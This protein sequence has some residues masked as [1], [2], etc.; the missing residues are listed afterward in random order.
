MKKL[1]TPFLLSLILLFASQGI[2]AQS[3]PTVTWDGFFPGGGITGN[4][5]AN[6]VKQTPDGGFVLVGT[7]SMTYQGN[8]YNEA[9]IMRIDQDG[10]EIAMQQTSSGA[11]QGIPWDQELNDLLITPGQKTT[12]LVTGFR[13]TTLLSGDTPPGL[14]LME[15]GNDGSVIF[16]SLYYNDNLHNIQGY[17]I[18]PAIEGGYIIAGSFAEDGGGTEQSFVTRLVEDEYG[19]YIFGD[20]PFMNLIPAGSNGYATWIQQFR[21][22][23]VMGGKAYHSADTKYDLF[24]QKLDADRNLVWTKFYGLTESDEFADAFVYGDTIYVAGSVRLPSYKYQIYVAKL[25]AAGD[26][27]NTI[28]ENTY[29]GIYQHYSN[30]IMMTG[31]GNLLVAGS[32]VDATMHSH[33]LLMKIDAETGDS[34]WTQ[35]YNGNY[36]NAGFRDVIR[37]QEFAYLTV[38]RADYSGTQDPRVNVLKLDDGGEKEHLQIPRE[39]LGIPIIP[40]GITE[41]KITFTMEV[42]TLQGFSVLFLSLLHPDMSE[43]ELALVHDGKVA[44][45]TDRPVHGGENLDSTGFRMLEYRPMWWGYAPYK[46]WWMSEDPLSVFLGDDPAGDWTLRIMDFGTGGA[47]ASDRVL[48]GWVLD[49]LVASTGG[50]T[51]IPPEEALANFG[52][53]Q[54]RPN[55]LQQETV[56]TFRIPSPGHVRMAVYNQLGQLVDVVADETLPEG[57]HERIWQPGSLAPGTYFIQLESGA[58]ISVTKAVLAR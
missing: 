21:D 42:D 57:V 6:D 41:D 30:K 16:D 43:L 50:G 48:E 44:V 34:L 5:T 8:G 15:I 1:A 58:R 4:Y 28:W 17:C 2:H 10:N 13:D 26:T 18:R 24:I 22:G 52:L 7:R 45:L 31:E 20:S 54:I 11:S 29:G 35:T 56:I 39:N 9:M 33:P 3:P 53:K 51:G 19:R 14:L 36:Y 25:K 38:G 27:L 46:G 12:Y 32:S 40:G 55:P 47:K 37:T 49:F 23:Y